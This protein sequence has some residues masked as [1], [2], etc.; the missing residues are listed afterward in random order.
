M[1]KDGG[2]HDDEK[3]EEESKDDKHLKI[4]YWDT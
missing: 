2:D 1:Y 3:E 4:L